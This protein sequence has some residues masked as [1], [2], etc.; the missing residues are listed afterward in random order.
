MRST[1]GGRWR[2]AWELGVELSSHGRVIHYATPAPLNGDATHTPATRRKAPIRSAT[3]VCARARCVCAR[4]EVRVCACVVRAARVT[5]FIQALYINVPA[6]SS[7]VVLNHG[8]YPFV[9]YCHAMIAW[10][11]YAHFQ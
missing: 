11:A 1:A 9:R 3:S 5:P 10:R 6:S 2:R 8:T 7:S 4:V